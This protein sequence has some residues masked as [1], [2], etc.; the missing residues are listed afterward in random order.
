MKRFIAILVLTLE[1]ASSAF[2]HHMSVYDDAGINI[3]DLST[4]LLIE[5]F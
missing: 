1:L 3:P 4:H 5:F 2:G